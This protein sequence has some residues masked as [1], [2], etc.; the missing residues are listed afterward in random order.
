LQLW[1][2]H[3]VDLAILLTF[4]GAILGIG[5]RVSR[6]VKHESDF[7]LGGRRLGPVLQFFLNF[8]NATDTNGAVVMASEVYRQGVG[9]VWL[10]LQTLFI[11]PFFWFTQ[12]WYR[13]A[14]V[15]TMADLFVD[16]FNSR[17]A[18][19]AYA[20]FNVCVALLLL[21]VGNRGSYEVAAAM[22]VK[23]ESAYTAADRHRIEGFHE[24]QRLKTQQQS[25]ALPPQQLARFDELDNLARRGQ[26]SAFISYVRPVPFYLGYCLIVAIYIMLGGLKAAAITDAVQGVL[27]L[28]MSIILIPIG[29][30]KVRGFTGLH[31]ALPNSVFQLV[32]TAASSEYAWYSIAAIT[33]GSLIQIIGLSHNMS[34]G[35]SATNEDTARFGMISGG[36]TKRIVLI[37]WMFCGLLAIATLGGGLSDPDKAWGALSKSLLGPG[38]MGL[39]LSGMLLGHMPSVGLS[40]VAVSGLVTRN[41]YE[42]IAPGRPP[43]HYL[44]VGQAIIAGV[45]AVSIVI[46]LAA[47]GV[48]SLMKTLIT[49]NI[50]FGA[51]VF[52]VFF[53]RRLTV[54]AILTSLVIWVVLIGVVPVLVPAVASLR[55]HPS[56]TLRTEPGTVDVSA[57][58][59]ADDV[60]AGRATSVNQTIRKTHTVAPVGCFFEQVARL[61][62][63]NPNSPLEGIGRFFTENYVLH[64]IGVPV[65]RFTPAGVVAARWLFDAFFPFVCLIV[66]SLMTRPTA[67]ERAGGFYAKL[68]TPV[69]PTPEEDRREVELSYARPSRFE[70]TKLFPRTQWEFTKWT[71]KDVVGFASCWCVVTLILLLLWGVLRVGS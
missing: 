22:V 58:A 34:S 69:A 68:K 70:N 17:A 6:G 61:D 31:A 29:L 63:K 10:S 57:P 67:I 19:M 35:G 50:F 43:A 59:N 12:P 48:A 7:Y 37:A 46:A 55:Q 40:S 49:F 26:L 64:L 21:G 36:F 51:V 11:T 2:L 56:L 9:G 4:L 14:R 42:P 18:A 62:P 60:R 5:I 30:Q 38:L 27:I 41:I 39:M 24:Y 66:L 33:F 45:L 8:G 3:I 65:E 20:G 13:R 54:P 15:I 23:P 71:L 44:R 28:C 1:G 16:R 32:G 47:S 52:L 53:W 25:G